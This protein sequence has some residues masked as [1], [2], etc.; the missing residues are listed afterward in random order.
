MLDHDTT[1]RLPRVTAPTLVPAG[2]SDHVGRPQLGRAVADA[3]P[4]AVFEIQDGEA[5][6][7]FQEI[8][9]AWN[10]RVDAF[11]RDVEVRL[12]APPHSEPAPERR[13]TADAPT[14]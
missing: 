11:W 6:Q 1:E 3:I 13:T 4:G 8:P 12:A 7:P 9:D 5:H 14:S 2:G 10:A